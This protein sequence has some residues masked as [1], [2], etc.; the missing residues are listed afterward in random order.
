MAH[1]ELW[2]RSTLEQ[3]AAEATRKLLE[4]DAEIER[5]RQGDTCGRMCEGTAYRTE[6][7]QLRAAVRNA[8]PDNWYE[9][10]DWVRLAEAHGLVPNAK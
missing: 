10:P 2:D 7:R 9:D 4:N 1:F 8:M 6:L 5:L 3:F